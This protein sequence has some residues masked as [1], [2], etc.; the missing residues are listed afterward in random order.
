M[1]KSTH[2]TQPYTSAPPKTTYRKPVELVQPRGWWRGDSYA[3]TLRDTRSNPWWVPLAT[4]GIFFVG[5]IALSIPAVVVAAINYF[6]TESIKS[7]LPFAHKGFD[8]IVSADPTSILLQFGGV[9]VMLPALWWAIYVLQRQ[10]FG[11]LSSVFGHIRW[12]ALG[13]STF[14]AFIGF[15]LLNGIS[16]YV[17]YRHGAALSPHF[18][19]LYAILLT[20]TLIPVQCMT[21]EYLFRGALIQTMGRWIPRG[22]AQIF[23]P[24]LPAIIFTSLHN[25]DWSGLSTVFCLGFIAGYLAMYFGGLEAGMG[26]HIS[27]N[28][29]IMLF[30]ACGFVDTSPSANSPSGSTAWISAGIDIAVQIIIAVIIVV[31]ASL[32]GWF[33]DEGKDYIGEFSKR[34]HQWEETTASRRQLQ[35]DYKVAAA[36]ATQYQ[37][38]RVVAYPP[39]S[40]V[41]PAAPAAPTPMTPAPVMTAPIPAPTPASAAAPSTS[42]LPIPDA[43]ISPY[44]VK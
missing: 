36:L 21:E 3:S 28:V 14:I 44:R 25:Y 30:T 22:L 33:M 24:I 8:P 11:S 15:M 1:Y 27:N 43:Q 12:R 4:F 26:M 29:T 41:V 40:P 38:A 19:N 37:Y 23:V 7:L 42:S 20:L 9:A 34:I 2:I 39:V 31:C 13:W 32:F 18:P 5:Y 17:D 6:G 16:T 10:S 35:R